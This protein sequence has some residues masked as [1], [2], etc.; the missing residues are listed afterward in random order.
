VNI[1]GTVSD[2][3]TCTIYDTFG[4]KIFETYLTDG[5]YNSFNIP[6]TGKGVYLVKVTD[7]SKVITNRV[8]F[9]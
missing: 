5:N 9:L 6:S 7:G 1:Q 4:R 8:V 2:K 3:A